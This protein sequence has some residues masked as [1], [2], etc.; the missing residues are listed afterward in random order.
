MPQMP[1]LTPEQMPTFEQLSRMNLRPGESAPA[2]NP[3]PNDDDDDGALNDGEED[4]L[5]AFMTGIEKEVKAKNPKSKKK[6]LDIKDARESFGP[7]AYARL[8]PQG[9]SERLGPDSM[10]EDKGTR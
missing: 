1:V 7:S 10:L 3:A 5:D 2:L 4:P 8:R 9:W 6:H